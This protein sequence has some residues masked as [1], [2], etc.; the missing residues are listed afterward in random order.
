MKL[1]ISKRLLCCASLVPQGARVA[2]VG[3]DHGYLS[4]HLLREHIAAAVAAMDLRPEPLEAAR[5]NAARFQTADRM[6]FF[7]CD[8]LSALGPGAVDAVVCAGMGGDT[9]VKILSECSWADDPAVTWILQPQSSGNDLRRWLSERGYRIEREKLVRDGGFLYAV[10]EV[11]YGGGTLLTP[12]QQYVSPQLLEEDP[13]LVRTY[14][15]RV[16]NALVRTVDGL[17]RAKED[18]LA[19]RRAYYETALR[20]VRE[21]E[22]DYENRQRTGTGVV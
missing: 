1:P 11:R 22:E 14:I 6:E 12:G 13:A 19:E 8:G 18:G 7:L 9:M 5:R 16:K 3:C 21:L 10:M 2:D 20:Q 15:E 4:I 17:S